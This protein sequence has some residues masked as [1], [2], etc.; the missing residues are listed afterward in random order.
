MT[1]YYEELMELWKAKKFSDSI[2]YFSEWMSESLLG[3]EEIEGF[4]RNLAKFWELV[5]I[6]CEE[7]A[8]VVFSLYAMLKSQKIGMMKRC[9]GNLKLVR[10]R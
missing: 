5:E 6:E 3:Q 9:A 2:S 1:A 7:N 4:N 8:E 10:K